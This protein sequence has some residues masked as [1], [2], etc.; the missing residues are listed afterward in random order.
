MR[1]QAESALTSIIICKE[2]TN[3]NIYITIII[4]NADYSFLI[5]ER[6]LYPRFSER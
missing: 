3:E 5:R 6:V 1:P 2:D 4:K